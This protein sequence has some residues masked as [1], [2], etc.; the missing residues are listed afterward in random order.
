MIR[1]GVCLCCA[2]VAALAQGQVNDASPS[3]ERPIP[4]QPAQ[5][6]STM[7][8]EPRTLTPDNGDLH[9]AAPSL[10]ER[11]SKLDLPQAERESISQAVQDHEYKRAET[12][13]VDALAK[14][15]RS[16]ELLSVAAG[17]FFLDHDFL[18]C[19][20]ALKKADTLRPLLPA[21]RFTLTLAYIAL[22]R[23]DWA[24]PELDRL[25]REDS[26]QPLYLYWLARVNY[27]NRRYEE[28]VALFRKVVQL[29]PQLAKGWDN[30]GLSL[31]G[32][33][34]LDGALTSYQ[35]AVRLNRAS[36]HPSS[37][38][39]LNEG[40]LLSKLGRYSEAEKS[41]REA[42]SYDPNFA[43]VRFRLGIV[44]DKEGRD[45]E[46]LE[47]LNHAAALDPK[48]SDPLYAL[49]RIYRRRG[50]GERAQK[51]FDAFQKLKSA[52]QEQ[53]TTGSQPR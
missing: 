36:P 33:G 51:A 12:K 20:I 53:N 10:A 32:L 39:P 44:Y 31:E 19:A 8:S 42:K 1:L 29:A 24:R 27:D 30:L 21:D 2:V 25:A 50:D 46:A 11:L 7:G 45:A 14:N 34:D 52:E 13:L 41:L 35:Q 16:P 23:P 22:H 3:R 17:V 15:P 28:A 38:P 9:P 47:E 37:W 49:G 4:A 26:G 48:Y 40:T 6:M 18:N 43:Q 5:P